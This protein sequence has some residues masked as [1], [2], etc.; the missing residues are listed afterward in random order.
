MQNIKDMTPVTLR[1]FKPVEDIDILVNSL[2]PHATFVS[3]RKG[4]RFNF[5][6]S[7]Q[8]LCYMFEEGS[9]TVHRARDGRVISSAIGPALLG[10]TNY[11]MAHDATYITINQ[12]MQLG[13][14]TMEVLSKQL[15]ANN[16][17][18]EFSQLLL[19]TISHF[20]HHNLSQV[21]PTSY[22]KIRTHILALNSEPDEVKSKTNMARY[23][24]DRTLLSRSHVMM[25]ISALRKGGHITVERGIL[26]SVA[27]LPMKF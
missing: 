23:I 4:Q 15:E 5:I 16:L 2:T 14:I 11:V 25:M 3:A 10:T 17:W 21:A 7:S 12:P 1:D 9:V 26:I 18:R 22:E 13:I 20:Q 19:F 24:Q 27:S 6:N 8:T